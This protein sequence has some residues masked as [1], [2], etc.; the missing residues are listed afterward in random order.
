MSSLRFAESPMSIG[1]SL[2]DGLT[3]QRLNA[4]ESSARASARGPALRQNLRRTPSSF[5]LLLPAS[6]IF[7]L[8]RYFETRYSARSL[9]LQ[10]GRSKAPVM[11]WTMP[12][13]AG[14]ARININQTSRIT[15][16]IPEASGAHDNDIKFTCVKWRRRHCLD[17]DPGSV[18]E[19]SAEFSTELPMC[20][21]SATVTFRSVP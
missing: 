1:M 5:S 13:L 18:P 10:P 9:P 14:R 2:A 17:N 7:A 6:A 8:P 15:C 12:V 21:C 16:R 3:L 11:S 19:K 4:K 20:S